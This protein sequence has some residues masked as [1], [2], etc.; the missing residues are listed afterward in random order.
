MISAAEKAFTVEETG[1]PD[2]RLA[3][4]IAEFFSDTDLRYCFE[5]RGPNESPL[6]RS[7]Y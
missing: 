2:T 7:L 4:E 3:H 5:V 6:H 1:I